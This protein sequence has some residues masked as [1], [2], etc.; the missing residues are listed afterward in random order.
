MDK[1]IIVIELNAIDI[2]ALDIGLQILGDL[3]SSLREPFAIDHIDDRAKIAEKRAAV[4]GV[5]AERSRTEK[6]PADITRNRQHVQIH[7]WQGFGMRDRC[8]SIRDRFGALSTICKTLHL[9]EPGGWLLFE[10][11][12]HPQAYPLSITAHH[13][14][15]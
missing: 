5:I 1:E 11:A 13:T 14:L 6:C 8:Q 7:R 9:L 2:P 4:R 15:H 10:S 12:A 3:F